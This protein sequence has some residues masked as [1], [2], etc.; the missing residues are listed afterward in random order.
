[1]YDQNPE[2]VVPSV[3]VSASVDSEGKPIGVLLMSLPEHVDVEV[4]RVTIGDES[5]PFKHYG[6]RMSKSALEDLAYHC[7]RAAG[8]VVPD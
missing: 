7:L 1:M 6:A 5:L 3:H 4:I 8:C 2:K